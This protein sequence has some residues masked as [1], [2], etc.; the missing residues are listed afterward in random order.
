MLSRVIG[1][2]TLTTLAMSACTSKT[3]AADARFQAIYTAEWTWRDE[4]FPDNEDAQKPIKD[5]LP[6]VDA[7]PEQLVREAG[8]EPGDVVTSRFL[9]HLTVTGTIPRAAT[10]GMAGRP[11]VGDTGV[12]GVTMAGDWV[13]PVGLLADAALQSHRTGRTVTVD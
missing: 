1:I 10:G 8:V 11:A 9:A 7:D 3:N 6:K 2:L 13:G 12:A 5:H 4:Q